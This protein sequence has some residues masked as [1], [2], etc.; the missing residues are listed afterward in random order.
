MEQYL[1]GLVIGL[2]GAFL[3]GIL[4][5]YLVFKRHEDRLLKKVGIKPD[6]SL[7]VDRLVHGLGTLLVGDFDQTDRELALAAGLDP[8]NLEL[9][10]IIAKLNRK[11]GKLNKSL[12]ILENIIVREPNDNE[13]V[14]RAF[15][16]MALDYQSA[17]LVDKAAT[18]LEQAIN[19]NPKHALSVK[20]LTQVYEDLGMY[21][22]ALEFS[23]RFQKL[24]K[25]NTGKQQAFYQMQ[26]GRSFLQEGNLK[27]AKR[28]F[29][30]SVSIDGETGIA[31]LELAEMLKADGQHKKA[32]SLFKEIFSDDTLPFDYIF[33][34]LNQS[35]AKKNWELTELEEVFE[36]AGEKVQKHPLFVYFSLVHRDKYTAENKLDKMLSFLE[37]YPRA[38]SVIPQIAELALVQNSL[39]NLQKFIKIVVQYKNQLFRDLYC[40]Q[41]CGF[42]GCQLLVTCSK[43]GS[44]YSTRSTWK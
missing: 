44:Q 5:A 25:E 28:C 16:E 4:F 12:K 22:S 7:I 10:F 39:D 43:C 17:G 3:L 18:V 35:L 38:I 32:I 13:L 42:E 30:K 24:S 19:I 29:Q 20:L 33:S 11:S 26:I 34:H 23:S 6:Y 21:V 8:E 1:F 9:Y 40:C 15:Y 41:V 2:A 14:V 37:A 31:K 36:T 27:E